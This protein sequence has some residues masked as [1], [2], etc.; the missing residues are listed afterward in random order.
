MEVPRTVMLVDGVEIRNGD[1][2]A[3]WHVHAS[4]HYALDKIF[5]GGRFWVD[6]NPN[7]VDG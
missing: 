3:A 6:R 7:R 5:M 4:V 2:A 1:H